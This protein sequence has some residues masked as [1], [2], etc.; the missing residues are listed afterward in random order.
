MTDASDA[1]TQRPVLDD[2]VGIGRFVVVPAAY[3]LLLRPASGGGA[4]PEVLLQLRSGTGYMDDHWAAGAAGHVE[5]G[6]TVPVAARREAHEELGVRP[7]LLFLTTMQRRAPGPDPA[8][9][10]DERVDF[11]FAATHWQG[12]PTIQEGA[13]CADLRWFPLDA[14]PDPVVP[15][16]RVALAELARVVG[17]TG[18]FV[19]TP[20]AYLTFGFDDEEQR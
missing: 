10:I 2:P 17:P 13:K 7:D 5:K 6:E 14:L 19:A 18:T 11:F 20:R 1:A 8:P 3:V 9:A 4:A 12:E 16:E 15:H